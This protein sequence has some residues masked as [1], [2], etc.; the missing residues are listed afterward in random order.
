DLLVRVGGAADR[1]PRLELVGQPVTGG[2]VVLVDEHV[3][4]LHGE[5]L[6][7]VVAA[8]VAPVVHGSDA[9]ARSGAIRC[10][11][12]GHR[13]FGGGEW[14][15]RGE[16]FYRGDT[17]GSRRALDG[18]HK[19]A[20]MSSTPTSASRE[21]APLTVPAVAARKVRDGAEPLVMVTA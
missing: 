18:I 1:A 6:G 21:R 2:L 9:T 4:A 15:H 12:R 13:P 8:G 10:D 19:E 14:N 20:P 7:P 17:A 16:R 3:D 11:R 5:Q